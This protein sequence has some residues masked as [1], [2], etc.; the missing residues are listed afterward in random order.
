[1][2]ASA[3]PGWDLRSERGPPGHPAVLP[4]ALPVAGS[5]T[6]G[7][8]RARDPLGASADPRSRSTPPD[9]SGERPPPQRYHRPLHTGSQTTRYL[10]GGSL[11]V[12]AGVGPVVVGMGVVSLCVDGW[13]VACGGRV[14]VGG[15]GLPQNGGGLSRVWVRGQSSVGWPCI[16]LSER[17]RE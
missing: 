3:G 6:P 13:G 10:V 7:C 9:G 15:S 8:T 17:R 16:D 5:L 2:R 11:V 4:S 14:L 1:M 12:G